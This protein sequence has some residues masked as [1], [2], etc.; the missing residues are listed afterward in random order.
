[1]LT[2]NTDCLP[3]I[4]HACGHNLIASASVIGAV[5][6]AEVMRSEGLP[7]KIVLFGTPAEEGEQILA[8]TSLTAT[9]DEDVKRTDPMQA[10]AA[11]FVC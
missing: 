8:I 1:L 6:A 10:A 2:Q 7:G 4:G 3:G 9:C 11:R 5:A